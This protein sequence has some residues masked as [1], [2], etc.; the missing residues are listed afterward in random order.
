MNDPARLNDPRSLSPVAPAWHTAILLAVLGIFSWLSASSAPGPG[1][2]IP[3]VSRP[4]IYVTVIVF[5]WLLFALAFWG[6]KLGGVSVRSLVAYRWSGWNGAVRCLLL[7]ALCWVAIFLGIAQGFD[8]IGLRDPEEMKRVAEMLLPR[9]PVEFALWTLISLTAGF[10]EEVVFRGYLQRQ[11]SA[12]CRNHTAGIALSALLF[13][14]GHLY[15]GL[16]SA[17]LIAAIGLCFSLFAYA[18]RSL[19]PGILAHATEDLIAGV[20]GRA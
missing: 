9:G 12:W 2:P 15:Q 11:L 18:T 19:A 10:V 3:A 4:A 8:L 13:G 7:A 16:S 1:D 14:A 6:L 20:V 17:V 5:Q